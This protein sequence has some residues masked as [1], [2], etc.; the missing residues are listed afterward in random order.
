[1]RKDVECTFGILK[2]RFRI[3]KTGIRLQKIEAV[4]KIWLTCC[5]LH[6]LLL[7]SDGLDEN[8]ESGVPSDWA[9]ELGEHSPED[10]RLHVPLPAAIEQLNLSDEALEAQL[11]RDSDSSGMGIGSDVI[12]DSLADE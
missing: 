9:G 2:G 7:E 5:A 4:D 12:R 8:W 1:M 10:V 6:N 11:G 3:L